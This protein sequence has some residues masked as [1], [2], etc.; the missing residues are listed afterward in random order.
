MRIR[1]DPE[2]VR[3]NFAQFRDNPSLQES[4]QLFARGLPI[5]EMLQA[6]S[7]NANV[8]AAFAG[9][10]RI[11]PHGSL[12]RP[13]LEKTILRVSQ[14][15]QCQFCVH[16]HLAM[17]GS[18]GVSTDLADRAAHTP[19]EQLAIEYAEAITR[20]SNRV[21]DELFE[22]LRAAFSDPEIVELTFHIGLITMLNRF[23]NALGVRYGSEFEQVT[24][25]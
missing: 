14:M 1:I 6:F 13:L 25:R 10:D 17:M 19:R 21:S 7:M 12:E 2:V 4:A 16:S 15:H 9:F 23:N 8:L 11:Y 18:L 22:R 3:V 5:V 24:V 20:D